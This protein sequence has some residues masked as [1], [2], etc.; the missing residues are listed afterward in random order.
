MTSE[1]ISDYFSSART[2]AVSD[3]AAQLESGTLDGQPTTIHPPN[4]GPFSTTLSTNPSN[5][6]SPTQPNLSIPPPTHE[7]SVAGISTQSMRTSSFAMSDVSEGKLSQ[8]ES[9]R[10]RK[11]YPVRT[12]R[13]RVSD[14]TP[15]SDMTDYTDE[16]EF[17][18]TD[19]YFP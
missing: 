19:R 6:I 14:V 5:P 15:Q 2:S 18:E 1:V 8:L 16:K 11:M 10:I 17:Q 13:D 4:D 7:S 9:L 12:P 3:M